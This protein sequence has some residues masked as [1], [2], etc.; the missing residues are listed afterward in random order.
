M[1]TLGKIVKSSHAQAAEFAQLV[2]VGKLYDLGWYEGP[3]TWRTA[4]DYP[5]Y[6]RRENE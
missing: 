5:E 4:M 3:Q 2:A 1:Q 6:A